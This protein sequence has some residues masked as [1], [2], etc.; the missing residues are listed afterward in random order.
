MK[1]LLLICLAAFVTTIIAAQSAGPLSGSTFSNFAIGGSKTSWTNP[2]NANA[3]D[4]LYATIGNITGGTGNYSDYLLATNF[5]FAI[6]ISV[7]I[8]SI[9]VEVKRSDANARTSDFHVQLIQNNVIQTTDKALTTIT[10]P[11]ADAYQYYGG[12]SLWGSTWTP[13]DI[14]SANFGVAIAAQR[15]V[16][17]SST[18]GKIDHIRITVFFSSS[19]LPLRLVDFSVQKINNTVRLNWITADEANMDHFEIE[20]S[21]K[22]TDFASIGNI[23]DNNVVTQNNYSYSDAHPLKNI[24]YY[25]L[26]MVSLDGAVTYSRIV[27]VQVNPGKGGLTLYPTVWRPGSPLNIANSN[28]EKLT[29]RFF[30]ESGQA[31]GTT[32][33]K[34]NVVAPNGLSN[35]L[36]GWI[37]Y[38]IYDEKDQLVGTGKVLAQ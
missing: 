21:Q 8:D 32:T 27:P 15:N 20:R 5:G 29:V 18:A 6:P 11:V 16:S 9:V 37:V 28:N 2:G 24:S 30:T 35:N 25:R 23:P 36:R 19:P 13:A 1:R 26:K 4:G 22:A 14:N 10:W 12:N 17:G 34:S 38:R 33:T 31:L 3:N 7:T